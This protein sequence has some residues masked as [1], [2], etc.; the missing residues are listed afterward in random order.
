MTYAHARRLSTY[1]T[2][3]LRGLGAGASMTPAEAQALLSPLMSQV[4]NGLDDLVR[5][6]RDKTREIANDFK[7]SW[8]TYTKAAFSFVNSKEDADEA[9][10][11]WRDRIVGYA[12]NVRS[13]MLRTDASG[14][15][16]FVRKPDDASRILKTA[17]ADLAELIKDFGD[18]VKRNRFSAFVV[19]TLEAII[20]FIM[21]IAQLVIV[22]F[23]RAVASFPVGGIAIVAVAAAFVWYKFLR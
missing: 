21:Q 16:F 6:A 20:A 10:D 9:A 13:I 5:T 23:G 12:E 14:K 17:E 7:D 18:E 4:R 15:P 19:D 8:W 3:S 2:Q 22:A 11:E 1:P